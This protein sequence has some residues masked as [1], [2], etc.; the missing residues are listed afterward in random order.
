MW[1]ARKKGKGL[2]VEVTLW[3]VMDGQKKGI[4]SL[5]E[6]YVLFQKMKLNQITFLT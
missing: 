5:V 6:E 1:N 3:D 2:D 4:E